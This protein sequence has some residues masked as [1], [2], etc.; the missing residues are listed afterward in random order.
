MSKFRDGLIGPTVILLSICLVITFA[1]AFTYGTTKPL[2]DEAEIKAANETREEVLPGNASFEKLD[3]A[4]PDGVFE[5]YK[6]D[7]GFVFKS[8]AKGFDGTVT[9]MIGIDNNGDVVGINMFDANETPGL[10]TK[11]AHPDYLG[12][13]FGKTD[14]DTVDAVTGATKTSNSLKNSIKQAK[15]AF[16]LVKGAK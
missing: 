5:V 16:E 3:V 8:G 11:I 7:G 10:G 15:A 4:L 9:Y 2:I 14:P 13:Y 6:A 12:K 1:L